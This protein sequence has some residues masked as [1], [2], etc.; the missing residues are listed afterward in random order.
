MDIALFVKLDLI[1][2][3]QYTEFSAYSLLLSGGAPP[4]LDH[5]LIAQHRQTWKLREYYLPEH[6]ELAQ[7]K[8][9]PL[10][11]G[12]PL[13]AH[14]PTG[15]RILQELSDSVDVQEPGT[16]AVH[17]WRSS[18]AKSDGQSGKDIIILGE[19]PCFSS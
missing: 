9:R 6:Q 15:T 14:F 17:Y 16:D 2:F 10:G 8:S 7:E 13:R 1:F 12:D 4:V 19:V 5:C 3:S 11:P 18:H